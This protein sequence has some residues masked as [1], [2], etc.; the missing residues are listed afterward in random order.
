MAD[1]SN[2]EELNSWEWIIFIGVSLIMAI[3]FMF[4]TIES[5]TQAPFFTILLAL[6]TL[7]LFGLSFGIAFTWGYIRGVR[8]E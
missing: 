5:Y 7:F 3:S 4:I 6:V 1:S 8:N 2:I